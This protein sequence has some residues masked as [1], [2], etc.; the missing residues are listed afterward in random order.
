MNLVDSS[1]WLEYFGKGANGARFAP[2]IQ[3]TDELIVPTVA[4]YEVFKRIASQRGDEEALSAVGFMSL[5]RS[6]LTQDIAL[7]AAALSLEHRLPMADSIILA[8]A[9]THRDS[10]DA[11]RALSRTAR[12]GVL[13]QDSLSHGEFRIRTSLFLRGESKTGGS[14]ECRNR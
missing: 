3:V 8:T 10:V 13:R 4:M 2:V 5:G 6:S 1:G 12:G 9:Q 14:D 11:R 7:E